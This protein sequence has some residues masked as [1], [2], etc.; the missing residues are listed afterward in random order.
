MEAL[1]DLDLSA[2]WVS[3]RLAT[4]T[5]IVL[6]IVGTP[7]AWWL[8]HTRSRVQTDHGSRGRAAYRASSH[9]PG[10]LYPCRAGSL[11]T[12]GSA[13]TPEFGVHLHG[14]RHRFGLLFHAVRDSAT[15]R[16]V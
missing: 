13:G 2:L 1:T 12:V 8:A 7:L 16:R 4:V 10:I 3:V 6:L 9:R 11:W 5:V 15:A 14:T